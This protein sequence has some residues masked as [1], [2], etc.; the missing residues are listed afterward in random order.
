MRPLKFKLFNKNVLSKENL[1]KLLPF[2]VNKPFQKLGPEIPGEPR[3]RVWLGS[4]GYLSQYSISPTS[5]QDKPLDLSY[6]LLIRTKEKLLLESQLKNE[7]L[8]SDKKGKKETVEKDLK[9]VSED[10]DKNLK[11]LARMLIMENEDYDFPVAFASNL[12][13]ILSKN[14]RM[15]ILADMDKYTDIILKK[16]D[17]LHIE[18]LAHTAHALAQRGIFEGQVWDAIHHQINSKPTFQIDYVKNE[19]Y[20]PTRF[21]YVGLKGGFGARTVE[22]IGQEAFKEEVQELIYED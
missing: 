2:S 6:Y 20:D 21:E 10:I 7:E 4:M 12:L 16:Q 13:Y 11:F 15:D 22:H 1:A 9:E 3:K 17:F 8:V 14:G 5:F 19:N 18:G